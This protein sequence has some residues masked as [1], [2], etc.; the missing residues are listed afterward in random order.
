MKKGIKRLLAAVFAAVMV[1]TILPAKPVEAASLSYPKKI[2]MY[3][4]S[5]WITSRI[6]ILGLKT[7]TKIKS[8][9]SSNR[10]VV[11]VEDVFYHSW[12]DDEA[13]K[14]MYGCNIELQTRSVGTANVTYKI[15]GKT[16]TTK[17]TVKPYENPVKKATIFGI[18]E[19]NSTNL[20]QLT[21]KRGSVW[22]N[23]PSKQASKK[24]YIQPAKNWK[25]QEI[26]WWA[27]DEMD[28]G[29]GRWY[30]KPKS[31]VSM[32]VTLPKGDTRYYIDVDFYNTKTKAH[33]LVRYTIVCD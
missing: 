10:D 32:N 9:K 30:D 17:V 15:N 14:E 21:A 28:F 19:K 5:A 6:E 31:S 25:V 12:Y 16:K 7:G 18:K 2:T 29:G 4:D 22:L 27:P 24:I 26:N 33:K 20:A 8:V 1:I 3:Q 11:G 23:A 13:K